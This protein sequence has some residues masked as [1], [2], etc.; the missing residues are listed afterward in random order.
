MY[1]MK[2]EITVVMYS[3]YLVFFYGPSMLEEGSRTVQRRSLR[4]GM[5]SAVFPT[6]QFSTHME[7]ELKYL[8]LPDWAC[9][10][11]SM[12]GSTS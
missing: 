5:V 9:Q 4:P 11:G 1:R 12:S 6:T 8:V 7:Q 2:E 3:Y 10:P